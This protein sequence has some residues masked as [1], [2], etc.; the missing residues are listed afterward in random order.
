MMRALLDLTDNLAGDGGVVAARDIVRL[1]GDDP[2][3]VGGRR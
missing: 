3:L 2:Y 1:D